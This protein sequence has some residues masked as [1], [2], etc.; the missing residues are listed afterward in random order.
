MN[1]NAVQPDQFGMTSSLSSAATQGGAPGKEDFLQLLVAQLAHQDPLQPMENTEFVAQL[2]QFSSLEQLVGVNTNL[3]ALSMAQLAMTNSQVAGLIGKEVEARGDRLHLGDSG[4]A[5]INF[6][7]PAAA[8]EVTVQVHDKSGNLIRTLKAGSRP[9]GL[10][11]VTWDGKD[12]M[13][14]TMPAG[15]YTVSASAVDGAGN[16]LDVSSRFQGMVTGVTY[17]NGIPLLEIGNTTLQVGDVLA[18]RQP[19]APE[20]T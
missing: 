19:S 3:D 14:N 4:S 16:A 13:G 18:V 8:R 10:N 2:A 5:D 11:S 1:I 9:S 12:E 6:D 15:A 7:L 17:E 20:G